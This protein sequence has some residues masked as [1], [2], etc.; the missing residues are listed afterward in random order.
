MWVCR[1]FILAPQL[2]FVGQ[3][4]PVQGTVQSSFETG[5][6]VHQIFLGI[7]SATLLVSTKRGEEDKPFPPHTREV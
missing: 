2:P 6:A 5:R 4:S 3:S 1:G 7:A